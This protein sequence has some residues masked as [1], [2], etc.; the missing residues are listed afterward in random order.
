MWSM[1]GKTLT[2][3]GGLRDR[4]CDLCPSLPDLAGRK[5]AAEQFC[6]ADS[7]HEAARF[8]KRARLTRE[9]EE[10]GVLQRLSKQR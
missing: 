6:E 1:V 9:A 10:E 8:I 2:R 7:E 4:F 3:S 5:G